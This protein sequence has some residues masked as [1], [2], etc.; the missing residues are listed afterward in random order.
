MSFGGTATHF[1]NILT[2]LHGFNFWYILDYFTDELESLVVIYCVSDMLSREFIVEAISCLAQ[3]LAHCCRWSCQISNKSVDNSTDKNGAT[4]LDFSYLSIFL[5][6]L[7]NFLLWQKKDVSPNFSPNIFMKKPKLILT[8][9][10]FVH[11]CSPAFI[12]I[13]SG[14]DEELNWI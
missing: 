3:I 11:V 14:D 4:A 8:G 13:G 5:H 12:M 2:I 1:L 7:L 9:W 6:Y 10:N